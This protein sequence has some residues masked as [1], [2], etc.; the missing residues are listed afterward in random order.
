VQEAVS[1]AFT[2]ASDEAYG[3]G[4]SA[5]AYAAHAAF[6][7]GYCATADVYYAAY[8]AVDFVA[9]A[10]RAAAAAGDHSAGPDP[11]EQKAWA[12][13]ARAIR[14][15]IPFNDVLSLFVNADPGFWHERNANW[16]G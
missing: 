15:V 12:A 14:E 8:N 16:P 4:W 11:G 2:V 6:N 10:A 7:A 9:A 5:F 13:C 1:P 3:K